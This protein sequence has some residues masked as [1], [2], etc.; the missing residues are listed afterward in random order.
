MDSMLLHDYE[1]YP[2][3]FQLSVLALEELA[4]AKMVS[5]YY[6]S[7]I[8]NDGFPDRDF[9]QEFLRLLYSHADKQLAFIAQDMFL[10]SPKFVRFIQGKRLDEKKQQ[11]T[12]VGLEKRGKKVDVASRIS[13]P[14]R[15]GQKDAKQLITFLN[16][17]FLAIYE[18]GDYFGVTDA[19]A[20]LHPD[21]HPFIWAWPHRSGLR[22]RHFLK[23][24][25]ANL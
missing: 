5:H 6:Y 23:Q 24:H 20:V 25:T 16:D 18:H 22:G 7:S 19:D 12:Y 15:I 9:E 17:E 3:A 11:A 10:Y 13:T 1:S 8:T 2:S 4:K 21:D 14:E